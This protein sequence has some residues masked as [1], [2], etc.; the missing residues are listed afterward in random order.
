M[1]RIL[2]RDIDPVPIYPIQVLSQFGDTELLYSPEMLLGLAV[3]RDC[4]WQ[5]MI[6]L[7]ESPN[8][9]L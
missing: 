6:T 3:V 1:K 8:S 4:L 5:I 9:K 7:L 2:I